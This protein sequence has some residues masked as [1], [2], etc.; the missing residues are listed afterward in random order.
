[1]E[2]AGKPRHGRSSLRGQ[3]MSFAGANES[4]GRRQ[5]KEPVWLNASGLF[6]SVSH[7]GSAPVSGAG[8]RVS[9]SRTLSYLT[10]LSSFGITIGAEARLFFKLSADLS[11]IF[12]ERAE[13]A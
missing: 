10:G 1:M 3:Q 13:I 6:V 8:D 11:S 12:K 5:N 7:L 4:V 2:R 9:Q